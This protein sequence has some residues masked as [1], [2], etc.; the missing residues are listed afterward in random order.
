MT[1][2]R[3]PWGRFSA[4]CSTC[5]PSS[6]RGSPVDGRTD[7]FA[8]GAILYEML[9]GRKAFDA[10][11]SAGVVAAVLDHTPQPLTV[12][13]PDVPP[14]LGWTV[15]Q[16]LTKAAEERWQSAADLARQLRWYSEYLC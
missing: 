15:A 3:P 4:R 10:D 12:V 11:S 9:T 14:E 7:I 13:R 16:C 8:V 5:R 6:S 2:R 1:R